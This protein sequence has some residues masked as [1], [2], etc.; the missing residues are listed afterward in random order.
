[1]DDARRAAAKRASRTVVGGHERV[2]RQ[3]LIALTSGTALDEHEYP[4]EASWLVVEGRLVL[5]ANGASWDARRGDLIEIPPAR[6]SV[7]AVEDAV[8][9]LSAVPKARA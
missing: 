5:H 7:T 4:G 8:F 3:T 9:L 1:L 6:H 2:L